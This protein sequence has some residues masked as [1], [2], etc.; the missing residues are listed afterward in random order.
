MATTILLTKND[1]GIRLQFTCQDRERNPINLTARDVHF[2]LERDG[3]LINTG[4]SR[5]LK[6]DSLAGKAAY[7][8][9]ISDTA[10]EGILKGRLCLQSD[11]LRVENLE[12][13][14]VWIK[15]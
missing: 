3:T 12:P 6:T 11:G 5:C 1:H 14:A 10:A 9:H 2:F 7:T 13:I 15:A 8:L 4:R